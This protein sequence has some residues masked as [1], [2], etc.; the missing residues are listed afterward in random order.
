MLSPL[1][2]IEVEAYYFNNYI[3]EEL[4]FSENLIIAE[5]PTLDLHV[6]GVIRTEFLYDQL[7]FIQ[8]LCA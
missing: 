3:T 6:L 8:K 2:H 1:L 7:I 4:C 5:L